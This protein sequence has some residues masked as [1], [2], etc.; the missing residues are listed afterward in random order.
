MLES[1]LKTFLKLCNYMNETKTWWCIR[2]HHW[3]RTGTSG[4]RVCCSSF[5]F[6]DVQ[7]LNGF[8]S[9]VCMSLT[10]SSINCLL[11]PPNE[12]NVNSEFAV[13]LWTLS[14]GCPGLNLIVK[15]AYISTNSV[16]PAVSLAEPRTACALQPL[17]KQIQRRALSSLGVYPI[18]PLF[19][20]Y[21]SNFCCLFRGKMCNQKTC[22]PRCLAWQLVSGGPNFSW[23]GPSM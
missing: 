17:A 2:V 12:G 7:G 20:R 9:R 19:P 22:L 4:S 6:R 16:S 11:P 8:N 15:S 14:Q 23:T 21:F 10:I 13:M 1:Q 3:A 18:H 5:C